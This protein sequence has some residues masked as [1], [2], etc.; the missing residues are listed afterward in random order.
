MGASG[1]IPG[2]VEAL[3]MA[4]TMKFVEIDRLCP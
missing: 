4:Y 3:D 1:M 2:V